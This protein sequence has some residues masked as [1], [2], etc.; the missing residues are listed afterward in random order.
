[1][2]RTSINTRRIW[3]LSHAILLSVFFLL[4][5]TTYGQDYTIQ[6][7][8]IATAKPDLQVTEMKYWASNC[9]MYFRIANNGAASGKFNVWVD[10]YPVGKEIMSIPYM[11]A[12]TASWVEK[13]M[14]KTNSYGQKYCGMTNVTKVRSVANARY[15]TKYSNYK[16]TIGDLIQT[17]T[18]T[19][20]GWTVVE[21]SVYEQSVTNNELVLPKSSVPTVTTKYIAVFTY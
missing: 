1:M 17:G 7:Y 5:L 15:L 10:Y 11:Y 12:N 13:S 4:P 14:W 20:Y 18:S 3:A 16:Y 2:D 6:S 19:P 21:R 9:T 8:S